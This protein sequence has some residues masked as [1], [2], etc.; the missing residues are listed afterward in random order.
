MN[1]EKTSP[2]NNENSEQS[3]DDKIIEQPIQN[4]DKVE[5]SGHA[6][7]S[8]ES[9]EDSAEQI[10]EA[11]IN[12]TNVSFVSKIF[13][14]IIDF[15]QGL[16]A[17]QVISKII[18]LFFALLVFGFT[19]M[20][21][22]PHRNVLTYMGVMLLMVVVYAEI[23][24]IRDHLWVIEGSMRESKRWR[25]I[26]FNHTTLRRQR[27]RKFILMFFTMV[28]FSYIFVKS[29][30]KADPL[31]SF[32]G[33]ILMITILYYEVLS[34]RDEVWVMT[35]ALIAG[36]LP[37]APSERPNAPQQFIS[38]AVDTGKENPLL[39]SDVNCENTTTEAESEK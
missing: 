26:F 24:V 33:I 37:D 32:M 19:Y 20:H 18:A 5:S 25:D 4:E 15:W 14:L 9:T 21:M 35:Q 29:H 1:E 23:L 36:K 2:E 7:E 22:S 8:K 6:A 12:S 17:R 10:S 30:G 13:A 28:V 3:P 34:I 38:E 16:M 11:H 39:N 31:L 27:I